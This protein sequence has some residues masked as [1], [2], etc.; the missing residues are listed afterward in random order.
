MYSRDP[1]KF[2]KKHLEDPLLK[3]ALNNTDGPMIFGNEYSKSYVIS[4]TNKHV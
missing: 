3:I 1:L 4:I 2:L